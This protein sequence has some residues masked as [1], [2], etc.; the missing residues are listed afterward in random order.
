MIVPVYVN[1]RFIIFV[2]IK[3]ARRLLLT[4]LRDLIR[5]FARIVYLTL[6]H[7]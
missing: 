1:R 2:L 3:T 6:L 5:R 7:V 4:P